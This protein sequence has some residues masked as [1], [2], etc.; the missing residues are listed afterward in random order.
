[1][2]NI[3][4]VLGVSNHVIRIRPKIEIGQPIIEWILFRKQAD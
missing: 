1:M 4:P 2:F 3:G